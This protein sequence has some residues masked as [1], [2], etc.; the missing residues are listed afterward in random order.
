MGICVLDSQAVYRLQPAC[1][2]RG[3]EVAQGSVRAVLVVVGILRF[4]VAPPVGH[5]IGPGSDTRRVA[6][7]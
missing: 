1:V 2:L 5:A 7:R 3:G 4:L 6:D